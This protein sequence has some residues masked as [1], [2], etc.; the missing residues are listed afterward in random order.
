MTGDPIDFLDQGDAAASFVAVAGRRGV[1]LDGAKEIFE[2]GLVA[3][4]VADDRGGGALVLVARR[5]CKKAGGGIAK[6]GGDDAV[7][8]QDH[9]A[10]RPGDF[11]AAWIA[12]VSR[13]RR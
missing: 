13:G 2:D 6:V 9:R 10:V 11:D 3:A 12:R 1:L 7:V 8:F 4:D 5:I